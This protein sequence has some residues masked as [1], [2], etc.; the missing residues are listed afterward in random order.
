MTTLW[1]NLWQSL[2]ASTKGRLILAWAAI[3]VL[4]LI[5]TACSPAQSREVYRSPTGPIVMNTSCLLVGNGT[6]ARGACNVG[7]NRETNNTLVRMNGLTMLI[8]RHEE[9]G[10][11][12]AYIVEEDKSLSPIASVV[13][14]GECWVGHKFKFCAK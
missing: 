10:T 3:S 6:V 12:T 13:A 1:T 8:K 4:M 11:A 9:E 2:T 14:V 7:M 5:L